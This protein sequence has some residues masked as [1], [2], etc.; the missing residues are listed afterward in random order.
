MSSMLTA[1]P[2]RWS[3]AYW[4]M[5]PWP[6]DSTKRSRLSHFGLFGLNLINLLH[7]TW[8]TGAMPLGKSQPFSWKRIVPI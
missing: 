7:K 8:A 6:L 1:K 2:K 5:Q 3:S 4:S